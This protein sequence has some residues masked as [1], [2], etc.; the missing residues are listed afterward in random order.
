VYCSNRPS[1]T[2]ECGDNDVTLYLTDLVC[3]Y[4]FCTFNLLQFLDIRDNF[5]LFTVNR[6]CSTCMEMGMTGILWGWKST[7]LEFRLMEKMLRNSGMD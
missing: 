6:P 5:V 1:N 3:L 7:L 2:E 4:I